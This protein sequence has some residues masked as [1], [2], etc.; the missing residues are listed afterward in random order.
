MCILHSVLDHRILVTTETSKG[1][2]AELWTV[3]LASFSDVAVSLI[4]EYSVLVLL[5]TNYVYA[6]TGHERSTWSCVSIGFDLLI[7]K[8]YSRSV[9]TYTVIS[10]AAHNAITMP[11]LFVLLTLYPSTHSY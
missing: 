11:F 2:Y 8:R 9:T 5:M 6:S 3:A 4:Q 1:H 7:S 10:I